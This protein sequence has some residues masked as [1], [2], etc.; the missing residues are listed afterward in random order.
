MKLLDDIDDA[1]ALLDETTGVIADCHE[2]LRCLRDYFDR[3]PEIPGSLIE[4]LD[5]T[6]EKISEG[7][8]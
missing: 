8:K 1:I 2:W 4:R 3:D 6:M 7:F 5:E